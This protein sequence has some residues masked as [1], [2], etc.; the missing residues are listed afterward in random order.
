MCHFLD[1]AGGGKM[2]IA[3]SRYSTKL[4]LLTIETEVIFTEYKYISV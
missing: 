3:S 4:F 2:N 1:A